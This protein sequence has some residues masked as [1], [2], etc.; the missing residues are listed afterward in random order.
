MPSDPTP[1]PASGEVTR[2]LAEVR[3]G[4]RDAFDRLLVLVYDEL[5]ALARRERRR[6][7]GETLQTTALV[8]EAYLKLTAN[9]LPDWKDRHHFLAVAA[10][11]MRQ[12]V[13]D[14]ARRELAEKRGGGAFR[15]ALDDVDLSTEARAREL[16]DL[17]EALDQLST[18]DPDLAELVELRFFGGLTVDEAA[19]A[20][21]TSPRTVKRGWRKAKAFLFE[22]LRQS[23]STSSPEAPE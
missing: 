22:A 1:G 5:R 14:H 11:A 10:R 6:D 7:P 20:L 16:V 15:L 21:G 8:H 9:R 17:D 18:V 23:P 12:I 2:L 13:I 4:R 19:D 3:A